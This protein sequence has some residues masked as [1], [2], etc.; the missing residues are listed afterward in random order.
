MRGKIMIELLMLFVV[1]VFL[2][3]I[4]YRFGIAVQMNRDKRKMYKDECGKC[5]AKKFYEDNK[6]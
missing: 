3:Y 6:V 4:F 5:P 2:A 1:M